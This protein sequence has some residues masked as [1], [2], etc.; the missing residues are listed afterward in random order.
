MAAVAKKNLHIHEVNVNN[1]FTESFQ[2][3]DIF[4]FP[5]PGVDIPPGKVFKILKSLYGLK[6]AAR[7]WNQLYVQKLKKLGFTRSEVDPCLLI[8]D[9]KGIMILT[10]VDDIPIASSSLDNINWFKE[11]FGKVFKIKDLGNQ[12]ILLA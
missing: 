8:H 11:E 7:D 10:W 6:Q 5:P 1:A 3:E 12:T 4:M 2:K 9:R